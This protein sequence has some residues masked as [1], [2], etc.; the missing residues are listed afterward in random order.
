MCNFLASLH[1]VLSISKI[2]LLLFALLDNNMLSEGVTSVVK[3]PLFRHVLFLIFELNKTITVSFTCRILFASLNI[4]CCLVL[5]FMDVCGK[6][7]RDVWMYVAKRGGMFDT[8]YI[9]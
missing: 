2:V 4:Y 7:R 6:T 5:M 1:C 8:L 3:S 9:S